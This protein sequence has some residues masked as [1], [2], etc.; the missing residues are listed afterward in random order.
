MA[1]LEQQRKLLLDI[2]R[3]AKL[4]G[5]N[6]FAVVE[7]QNGSTGASIY[8]ATGNPD[9]AVRHARAAHVEWEKNHGHDPN[10]DWSDLG[11]FGT[12]EVTRP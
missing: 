5:L 3:R 1:T 10:H 12:Q 9:G 6:I 2:Q 4:L 11:P 7:P 8:S